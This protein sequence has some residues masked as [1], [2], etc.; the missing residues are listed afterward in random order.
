MSML[1]LNCFVLGGD[2]SEVFTVK[3]PES[4]IVSILKDLIKEKRSHRLE[5]VDA[6]DLTTYPY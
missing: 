2:S 1:S 3:I 6:S 4:K 5:H